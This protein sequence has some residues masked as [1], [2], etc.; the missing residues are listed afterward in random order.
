MN[1]NDYCIYTFNGLVG[2]IFYKFLKNK[3]K[4]QFTIKAI[5]Y[6]TKHADYNYVGDKNCNFKEYLL[7]TCCRRI[8]T[9]QSNTSSIKKQEICRWIFN[10][11]FNSANKKDFLLAILGPFKEHLT[12]E[13]TIST[14]NFLKP[15]EILNL[16]IRKLSLNRPLINNSIINP[17]KEFSNSNDATI[18]I[19]NILHVSIVKLLGTIL[20]FKN[21]QETKFQ[22]QEERERLEKK[23]GKRDEEKQH[24]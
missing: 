21:I 7:N 11:R 6:D 1:P 8:L 12:I 23:D 18:T 22:N 16:I 4:Q 10:L 17:T 13:A 9:T 3:F 19:T 20:L 24:D 5:N 2:K 15:I 14:S